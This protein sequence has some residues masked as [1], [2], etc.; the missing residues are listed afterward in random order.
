MF[1]PLFASD[2][3]TTGLAENF[4]ETAWNHVIERS[5]AQLIHIWSTIPP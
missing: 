2:P 1:S 3:K 4:G 5:P